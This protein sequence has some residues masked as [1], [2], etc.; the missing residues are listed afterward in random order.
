MDNDGTRQSQKD[1][2]VLEIEN[3]LNLEI[4]SKRKEIAFKTEKRVNLVINEADEEYE[5]SSVFTFQTE[6]SN[7]IPEK[8]KMS[9]FK[10]A[11][12]MK[13]TVFGAAQKKGTIP[14]VRKKVFL[15]SR[16]RFA[17]PPT[18]E[19][20]RKM[21]FRQENAIFPDQMKSLSTNLISEEKNNVSLESISRT[22]TNEFQ[23]E[24]KSLD[25]LD[26]SR[27]LTEAIG[28]YE[29]PRLKKGRLGLKDFE[30]KD[31]YDIK[32][33]I[34]D[35]RETVNEVVR[36]AEINAMLYMNMSQRPFRLLN[37]IQKF[38][39]ALNLPIN[40]ATY[41]TIFPTSNFGYSKTRFVLNSFFA[42]LFSI[43][44]ISYRKVLFYDSYIIIGAIFLFAIISAAGTF[45]LLDSN[46]SPVGRIKHFYSAYGFVVAVLWLFMLSDCLVSIIIGFRVLFNYSY[47]FM[48]LAAFS[49]WAWIPVVFGSLRT[50]TLVKAMPGYGGAMFNGMFVFGISIVVQC[51]L[52][53]TEVAKIWPAYK[54]KGAV[55]LFFYLVMNFVCVVFI[56][57]MVQLR[58]KRYTRTMG[59][60]L[61]TGYFGVV[62]WTFFYGIWAED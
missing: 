20:I 12:I 61:V 31:I 33:Y 16:A 27:N 19:Q 5:Q 45:I 24:G 17:A 13:E 4:L 48:M 55:Q 34:I 57:L 23:T 62:L 32:K 37:P 46:K 58:A 60:V 11:E 26:D 25:F 18:E 43:F 41:L 1:Q 29:L 21:T 47:T 51:T 38:L 9:D 22:V 52:H 44:V 56:Y 15:K 7:S 35:N 59:V 54:G 8:M 40:L 3:N 50:V 2:D 6:G 30:R 36:A 28:S 53:E 14:Y 39:F 10:T 49:F 42:P